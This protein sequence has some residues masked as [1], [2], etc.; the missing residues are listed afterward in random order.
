MGVLNWLIH[1]QMRR[2]A[3][4]L[5]EW[6]AHSYEGFREQYPDMSER[7]V[8]AKVLDSRVRFPGGAADRQLILDKYGSSIYNRITSMLNSI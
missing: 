1:R 4:I 5:A 6:A 7:E 2:H 3:S 8:L